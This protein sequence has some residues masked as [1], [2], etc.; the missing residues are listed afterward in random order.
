M[1][2]EDKKEITKYWRDLDNAPRITDTVYVC[3]D[4]HRE[5]GLLGVTIDKNKI[6]DA[7]VI[8]LGDVGLGFLVDFE[9]RDLANLHT[10]LAKNSV[11][12]WFIRGNHDNPIYWEGEKREDLEFAYPHIKLPQQGPVWINDQLFYILPGAVSIDR[13]H[14]T[15]GYSCWEGDEAFFNDRLPENIP[16]VKGI[17]GHTGPTP[18]GLS[19]YLVDHYMMLDPTLEASLV[20]ERRAVTR[21]IRTLNPEWYIYGHYHVSRTVTDTDPKLR[22][23]APHEVRR[24]DTII[25]STSIYENE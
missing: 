22:V 24:L 1:N 2:L 9:D 21:A 12:V 10:V 3:G 13:C 19:T 5:F 14:R 17:L 20:E 15:L 25:N 11:T 8:V 7:T 18:P 6:H 16:A 23:L 4:I